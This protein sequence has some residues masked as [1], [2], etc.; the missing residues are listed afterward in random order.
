MA[1]KTIS[2]MQRTNQK[3]RAWMT[4]NG[5]KDITFFPHTRYQKDV[6]F[7][8]QDFDGMASC[9]NILVM[10]QAKSNC[11]ATKKVVA[12]Y[13]EISSRMKISCLWINAIDRKGLEVNNEKV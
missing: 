10:F 8:G 1:I 9:G 13:A 4:E 12:E 6:H 11:K 7:Q 3:V 2:K 5:Y